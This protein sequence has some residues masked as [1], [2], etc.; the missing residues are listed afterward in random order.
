MRPAPTA[1]TKRLTL[2]IPVE[3]LTQTSAKFALKAA[4][5]YFSASGKGFASTLRLKFVEIFG[6]HH[7]RGGRTNKPIFAGFN[8]QFI[9]NFFAGVA[10]RVGRNLPR[11]PNQPN[12]RRAANSN[13]RS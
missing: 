1:V 12:R 10:D 13:H 8:N 9:G 2:T 4:D 11:R 5:E 3:S 6:N 7:L